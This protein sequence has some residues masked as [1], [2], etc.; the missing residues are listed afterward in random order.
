[1]NKRLLFESFPFIIENSYTFSRLEE[2]DSD[3]LNEIFESTNFKHN[4]LNYIEKSHKAF[5]AKNSIDMGFCKN[6][7]PN[8]LI[9]ITTLSHFDFANN[10]LSINML[11]KE[12]SEMDATEALSDLTSYLFNI[13]KVRRISVELINPSENLQRV[14]EFAQFVKE[15]VI[16]EC[17][18]DSD[19]KLSDIVI[20]GMLRSDRDD[21]PTEEESTFDFLS[22]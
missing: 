4:A 21:E 14:Y 6:N 2:T 5:R 1:M 20:Y 13:V 3:T 16:R 22:I 12:E 9:G 8:A 10:S 7:S 11:F 19:K 18:I 17:Y 15:G